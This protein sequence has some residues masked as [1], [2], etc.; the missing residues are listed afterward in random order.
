MQCEDVE[1]VLEQEGL[2]PLPEAARAHVAGCSHCQG[3]LADLETIVSL[4]V[5]LPDEVTP[6]ERV[7]ISLRA[8]LERE[9]ILQDTAALE[10]SAAWWARFSDLFRS[11]NLATVT[12]GLVI[13]MAGALQLRQSPEAQVPSAIADPGLRQTAKVLS[14]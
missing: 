9:G 6:P 13:A 14:D 11:R 4:A 8:Q 12:V 3:L 1:L 2:A 5:G 7:W 10:P